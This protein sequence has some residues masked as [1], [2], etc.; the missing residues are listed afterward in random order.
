MISKKYNRLKQEAICFLKKDN[1][2]CLE[3]ANQLGVQIFSL[4][5]II[6]RNSRRLTEQAVI[7]RIA[8]RMGREAT[9]LIETAA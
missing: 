6:H 7:S 2:L 1:E 5:P 4:P 3:V 8:A 9:E